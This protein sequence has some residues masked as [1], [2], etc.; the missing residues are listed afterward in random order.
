MKSFSSVSGNRMPYTGD[1]SY[2]DTHDST[3]PRG[4]A[5]LVRSR[6]RLPSQSTRVPAPRDVV[7]CGVCIV[8]ADVPCLY[9]SLQSRTNYF[10][11]HMKAQWYNSLDQWKYY[12]NK[13][14]WSW[15]AQMIISWTLRQ[16]SDRKCKPWFI[17]RCKSYSLCCSFNPP[18]ISELR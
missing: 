12:R 18:W 17:E 6:S 14:S 3:T 4:A 5:V 7:R 9:I 15:P 2:R 10:G 16:R 13:C 11:I 1:G 8:P